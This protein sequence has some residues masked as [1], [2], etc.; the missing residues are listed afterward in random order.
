MW[1]KSD[2]SRSTSFFTILKHITRSKNTLLHK[3]KLHARSHIEIKAQAYFCVEC[4]TITYTTNH[5]YGGEGGVH[6][7][8][9]LE[10]S[11]K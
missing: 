4:S 9:A 10:K 8:D 6:V 5:F 2:A 3:C 1:K 7:H 11:C